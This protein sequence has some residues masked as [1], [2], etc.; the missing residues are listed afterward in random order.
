MWPNTQEAANSITFTE[1]IYNGKLHFLRSD[2]KLPFILHNL[3]YHC[4]LDLNVTVTF[5][6]RLYLI[7]FFCSYVFPWYNINQMNRF[8][9][10]LFDDL[11]S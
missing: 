10:A 9:T 7:G 3:F 11:L 2:C 5:L 4:F 8:G 1:E 6:N